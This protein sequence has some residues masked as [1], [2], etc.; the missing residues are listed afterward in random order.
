MRR[1]VSLPALVLTLTGA[2]VSQTAWA[3]RAPSAHDL[4]AKISRTKNPIKRARLEIELSRLKLQ[5]AIAAYNARHPKQGAR[6]LSNYLAE[7]ARCRKT[8]RDSGYVASKHPQGFRLFDITLRESLRQLTF[9]EQSVSY[10][11][12]SPIQKAI[13]RV[14]Q[15]RQ[16]NL[17]ALFPSLNRNGARQSASERGPRPHGKPGVS[18]SAFQRPRPNVIRR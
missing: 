10:L 9:L 2:V 3:H 6:L 18:K 15:I 1:S 11:E 13:R 4:K 12:L 14:Q 16:A 5:D 8:L 7:I 17:E